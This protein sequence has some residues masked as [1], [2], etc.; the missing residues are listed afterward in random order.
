M[1]N[2]IYIGNRYVPIFADPVEWNNLREYEALTIVT[3]NGTAYTSRKR[4]PVGTALSNTEYWVVTGNYNAQ[5]EQYRQEVVGVQNNLDDLSDSVDTR[6]SSVNNSIDRLNLGTVVCIGDSYLEGYTSDGNVTPWGDYLATM[7][8]KSVGTTLRKYAKGGT[9]FGT[10]SENKN[11]ASLL[12]DSYTDI[13]TGADNVGAVVVIG[14][15]NEPDNLSVSLIENFITQAKTYYP[16][17]KV[18]FGYGSAFLNTTPYHMLNVANSYGSVKDGCYMGNIAKFLSNYSLYASDER[19]PTA[20]GH[21]FIA[22]QI[23]QCII[24]GG[25]DELNKKSHNIADNFLEFVSNGIYYLNHFSQ[26]SVNTE[27]ANHTS[28][29]FVLAYTL[30]TNDSYVHKTDG[31]FFGGTAYGYVKYGSDASAYFAPAIFKVKIFPD[32][33]EFYDFA[34]NPTGTNYAGGTLT[35]INVQNFVFSLPADVM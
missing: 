35:Q 10:T 25:I 9:G 26:L 17:A 28:S 31:N 11:F 7:L 5:V 8:N 4:V 23:Y 27:I 1:A 33:I 19:H 21:K 3:Y 22:R 16:N 30:N 12:T 18:F 20:D 29:G 15:A 34:M 14:G 2:N 6:F 32:K 13:G 24:G